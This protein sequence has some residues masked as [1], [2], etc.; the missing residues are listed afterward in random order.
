MD[1]KAAKM[2]TKGLYVQKRKEKASGG[3]LKR[4]KVGASSFA[5]PTTTVAASEIDTSVEVFLT[6]EV[7]TIGA[8]FLP[9][10]PSGPSSRDQILEL[11]AEGE[12]EEDHQMLAY[13]KRVHHQEVKA[14]KVQEDL[15]VET[16]HLHEKVTKVEHLT[17]EKAM[18]IGSLQVFHQC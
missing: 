12:M 6:I 14:Q 4:A 11:P 10:M 3:S 15:Q 1:T 16:S 5:A 8:G 13:I 18:K 2:L 17:E 7:S 9:P